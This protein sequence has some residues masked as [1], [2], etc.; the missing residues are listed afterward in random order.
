[1]IHHC[2][3]WRANANH[4]W[5]V[6]PRSNRKLC[7]NVNRLFGNHLKGYILLWLNSK[8]GAGG[9]KKAHI[10]RF[11]RNSKC[12][13]ILKRSPH[14]HRWL[15][16]PRLDC[17]SFHY[18]CP[19]QPLQSGPDRSPYTLRIH[20]QCHLLKH[21]IRHR[22]CPALSVNTLTWILTPRAVTDLPANVTVTTIFHK[23][24]RE[25]WQVGWVFRFIWRIM[26][27]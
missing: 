1:M 9:T 25:S 3:L 4:Q 13:D 11:W 23:H 7:P 21:T 2:K 6:K 14:W 20:S 19:T 12:Q 22:G 10:E 16:Q 26:N 18:S 24:L 17:I 8:V 5:F 27:P 15:L